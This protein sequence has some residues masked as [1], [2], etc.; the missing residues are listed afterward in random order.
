MS[1]TYNKNS[2]IKIQKEFHNVPNYKRKRIKQIK[3]DEKQTKIKVNLN[4]S[5]IA[6]AFVTLFCE[7]YI[8]SV[9]ARIIFSICFLLSSI[10]IYKEEE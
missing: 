2:V 9:S 6:C 4:S 8:P 1:K 10:N 3:T 5:G 7:N